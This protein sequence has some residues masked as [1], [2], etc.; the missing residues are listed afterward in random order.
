[1]ANY[2]TFEAGMLTEGMNS[3]QKMQF[4]RA[5][6]DSAKSPS[7]AFWLTMGPGL[8][9]A[10]HFYLGD[11]KHGWIQVGL[12]CIGIGLFTAIWDLFTIK[13]KTR[14]LNSDL[15][16]RIA[17]QIRGVSPPMPYQQANPG[18]NQAQPAYPPSFP[19]SQQVQ[20]PPQMYAANASQPCS[21]C[22]KINGST[23]RFCG[24]CGSA[25]SQAVGSPV[26][27]QQYA[28]A[29]TGGMS[30]GKKVAIVG[31]SLFAAMMV[32][33][34]IQSA[35]PEGRAAVA[36]R[37]EQ[38]AAELVEQAEQQKQNDAALKEHAV[39]AS[40]VMAAYQRNEISADNQFKGKVIVVT[41]RIGS[42]AKDIL[43]NPYV[44]LD[45]DQIGIGSVQCFFD[46]SDQPQM[47]QLSPGQR[48]YIK[49]RVD[50]KFITVHLKDAKILE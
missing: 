45:E 29:S 5:M 27:G 24:G 41:G 3:D 19:Q 23:T 35:T 11:T 44:T 40:S 15:A 36:A 13:A 20:V 1:M 17:M 33:G 49:G 6:S 32:I 43:D 42:I 31:G 37:K 2:D 8:F 46:D 26:H 22:G 30:T 28:A 10:G 16:M 48:V 50:E 25:V 14:K 4:H 21:T 7:T 47:A 18:F 9:G 38:K 34:A 12:G 39:S